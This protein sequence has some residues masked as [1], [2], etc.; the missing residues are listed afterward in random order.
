M[1]V[2]ILQGN[3]EEEDEKSPGQSSN[4]EAK[5]FMIIHLFSFHY[6]AKQRNW[7]MEPAHFENCKRKEPIWKTINFQ[8]NHITSHYNLKLLNEP[9]AWITLNSIL[10]KT[11]LN[12]EINSI[13]ISAKY[14]TIKHGHQGWQVLSAKSLEWYNLRL[15]ELGNI[16]IKSK[17]CTLCK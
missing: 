2:K 14:R 15:S 1:S 8:W 6:W 16:P 9:S 12:I 5:E 17:N 10:R 11:N 4:I 13:V 3:L 7:K